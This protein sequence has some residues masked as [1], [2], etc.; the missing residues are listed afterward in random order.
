MVII[1]MKVMKSIGLFFLYPLTMYL[2]GG[3]SFLLMNHYFYSSEKKEEQVW[4]EQTVVEES[5][6][7]AEEMIVEDKQILTS[8]TQYVIIETDLRD[9]SSVETTWKVPEMYIGMDRDS[10]IEAMAEYEQSPPLEEQTRGFVSVEVRSF[11]RKKVVIRKNYFFVE[12][13]Q[14]FYLTAQDNYVVVMCEDLQ[15]VYMNTSILLTNLPERLQAEV[16]LNKYIETEKE[17][18]D[19]LEA[20][21]S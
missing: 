13:D 19:F 12:A 6:V 9:G 15:T 8:D 4:P 1:K 10:F 17:L 2:L 5:S 18:Y 20:Y 3:I 21:S 7:Q 14:H 11:S 16:L